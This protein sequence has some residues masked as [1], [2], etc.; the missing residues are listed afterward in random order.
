MGAL[1]QGQPDLTTEVIK[2]LPTGSRVTQDNLA[3][4][5]FNTLD[6]GIKGIDRQLGLYA[7]NPGANIATP[8]A[9][10]NTYL[11]SGNKENSPAN[12]AAYMMRSSCSW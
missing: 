4:A 6:A 3:P 9:L 11:G 7:N 2:S 12:R 1:K 8:E 10:A 5:I